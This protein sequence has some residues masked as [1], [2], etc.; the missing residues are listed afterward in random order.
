MC[1]FCGF[2][3]SSK[4]HISAKLLSKQHFLSQWLY[5]PPPTP[6]S[7]HSRNRKGGQQRRNSRRKSNNELFNAERRHRSKGGEMTGLTSLGSIVESNPSVVIP[8]SLAATGSGSGIGSA[9]GS[10]TGTGGSRA[11]LPKTKRR[12]SFQVSVE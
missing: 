7:P 5:L 6:S 2:C 3:V 8:S 1:R 9:T 12:L 10:G 11:A 4:Q